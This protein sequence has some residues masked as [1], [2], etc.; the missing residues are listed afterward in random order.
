MESV[1][2]Q[3]IHQTQLYRQ[4]SDIASLRRALTLG[5]Q[6]YLEN[7]GG[8]NRVPATQAF[9][10]A[11]VSDYALRGDS[12]VVEKAIR[13]LDGLL[14]TDN[15][16]YD[17]T[18]RT[19]LH[20]ANAARYER[21][22]R[23]VFLERS[24][25]H[26][27]I[28]VRRA[29]AGTPYEFA[30][31]VNLIGSVWLLGRHR[32]DPALLDEAIAAG[33]R[34]SSFHQPD[35]WLR[36]IGL[37]NFAN[38][39]RQRGTL[40][41]EVKTLREA[42]EAHRLALA[43]PELCGIRLPL[44]IAEYGAT[45][46]VYGDRTGNREVLDEAI[47][48]LRAALRGQVPPAIRAN[49]LS[50]LGMA[51]QKR[52]ELGGTRYTYRDALTEFE[53]AVEIA[54]GANPA[55]R[56][57]MVM[58]LANALFMTAR[59]TGFDPAFLRRS[60]TL[61]SELLRAPDLSQSLRARALGGQVRSLMLL[62]RV[63]PDAVDPAEVIGHLRELLPLIPEPTQRV[64]QL[65]T[66]GQLLADQGE[67][68]QAAGTLREAIGQLHR[69]ASP[70]HDR[71]DVEHV[72]KDLPLLAA[73]AAACALNNGDPKLAV[74][75][76][77][78]GRGILMSHALAFRGDLSE[79][80]DVD[81]ALHDRLTGILDQL[82][83]PS[84]P[85][86][87]LVDELERTLTGIRRRIPGFWEAPGWAELAVAACEGPVILINVSR[88]RCDALV[89]RAGGITVRPLPVTLIEIAAM[90]D[91][92]L[93]ALHDLDDEVVADT[94]RRL[95]ERV[96]GPALDGLSAGR[97]WWCPTGPLAWLP[98]H[99][100]APPELVSSYTPTLRALI[101]ARRRSGLPVTGRRL[102]V[103][104]P[105]RAPGLPGGPLTGVVREI[106]ALRARFPDADVLIGPEAS[107]KA[108]TAA[109]A[110]ASLVHFACHAYRQ[111]GAM[112]S[113]R[114]LLH[115]GDLDVQTV[116]RLPIPSA[117]LAF[118]SACA[119]SQQDE[120]LPDEPTT[121]AGSMQIA[122][123]S[124]VVAT[125]WEVSD[126]AASRVAQRFYRDGADAAALHAAVAE[127]RDRLP[128]QPLLWVP[129]IHIGP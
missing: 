123:F 22:N 110:G 36:A 45:L 95:G 61:T 27:R 90:A 18:T 101:D 97:V 47:T 117:S 59:E 49:V 48:T 81:P 31:L 23:E 105:E 8:I 100:A 19:V 89:V 17:A 52:V 56:Q 85:V 109:L 87:D 115:D 33:R 103:G 41:N 2:Q 84:R 32:N 86:A 93:A 75:L 78:H 62:R 67:W 9:A 28:G 71:S 112:S 108:V 72:V 82:A 122:G 113:G 16:I 99:A 88:H 26:S 125:L 104:V 7:A 118:L 111:A 44:F 83:A 35:P 15:D 58:N 102:L 96:V 77:E 76:L 121:L 119:T 127:I 55:M 5:E 14:P 24:A 114:L 60:V 68:G 46:M 91:R 29:P 42:V 1:I 39:L 79:L 129:F 128:G 6:A 120:R 20:Q 69:M 64:V 66:L 3:C 65:G 73:E 126:I 124:Q 107:V 94:V 106:D 92:L 57:D 34:I 50:D 30:N 38:A 25:E 13:I 4:T 54:A 53:R 11:L 10:D 40:R 37:Q 63:E 70:A 12:A 43:R 116:A 80:H 98:L 74:S 51:L 21:T